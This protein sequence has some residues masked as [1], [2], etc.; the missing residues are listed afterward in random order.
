MLCAVVGLALWFF[1]GMNLGASQWTEEAQAAEAAHA[2]GQEQRQVFRPGIGF[3]AGTAL[4][5]V[6]LWTASRFGHPGNSRT[7]D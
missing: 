5:V 1:G 6:A 4:V 3:L 7:P 2:I